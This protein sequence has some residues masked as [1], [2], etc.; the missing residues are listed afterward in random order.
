M[1]KQMSERQPLPALSKAAELCN[2]V[3]VVINRIA[4]FE[5]REPGVEIAA[6][7]SAHGS[8][9]F[10]DPLLT[11]HRLGRMYLVGAGDFIYSIGKLLALEE[12][13]VNAPAVAARSAAEYASRCKY[14]SDPN[15][16]P[17]ARLAK[18]SHLLSEGIA[19]SGLRSPNTPPE[20][21]HLVSSFD[22]WRSRQHLP[23]VPKP[24]YVALV[25]ELSP[26]MGVPEYAQLSGYLHGSALTL[27]ASFI[28]AQMGLEHRVD[29]SWRHVLF[30]AECGLMAGVQ[31]CT[32]RAGDRSEIDILLTLH[33][34]Y[35]DIYNQY[36]QS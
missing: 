26:H 3:A 28:S 12:P 32:L 21:Q 31:V 23:R 19:D 30:A 14:I 24:K 22:S 8:A 20:R 27:I 34:H 1:P 2:A 35:V 36:Q 33:R 13:M 25:E 5:Y 18:M 6:F 7:D 9:D 15:D 11:T 29:N 10:P 4:Y 17:G 16:S